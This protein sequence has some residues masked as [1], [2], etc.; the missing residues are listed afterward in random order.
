[1]KVVMKTA[2]EIEREREHA[3]F[4]ERTLE[5]ARKIVAMPDRSSI[6]LIELEYREWAI[7]RNAFASVVITD[8]GKSFCGVPVVVGE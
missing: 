4:T 6:K 3:E 5:A 8:R 7:I 2:A 1:M